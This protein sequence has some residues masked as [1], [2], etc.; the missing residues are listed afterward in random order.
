MVEESGLSPRSC[1]QS[2]AAQHMLTGAVWPAS[3]LD[4]PQSSQDNWPECKWGNRISIIRWCHFNSLLMSSWLWQPNIV[5]LLSS[6]DK[7]YK[8]FYLG[9]SDRLDLVNSS[10]LLTYPSELVMCLCCHSG[11]VNGASLIHR[12]YSCQR[13]TGVPRTEFFLWSVLVFISL[14]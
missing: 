6:P 9:G 13:A 14:N 3:H 11:A 8:L 10:H 7:F 5:W 1:R 12:P 4:S 2:P